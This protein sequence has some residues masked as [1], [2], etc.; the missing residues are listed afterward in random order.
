MMSFSPEERFG[1]SH[2][3]YNSWLKIM[4]G[5]FEPS[6]KTVTAQMDQDG[7]TAHGI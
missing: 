2:K 7:E 1:K 5:G 6:P 3:A 4:E